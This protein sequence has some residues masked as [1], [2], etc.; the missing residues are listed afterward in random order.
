MDIFYEKYFR[1]IELTSLNFTRSI[2]DNIHW[3][4]RLIGIKG[5]RDVGKTTLLLQY[6]K[7]I[8]QLINQHCM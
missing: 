4:A 7:K 1:K 5:S 3:V 2:M 6:I 8:C